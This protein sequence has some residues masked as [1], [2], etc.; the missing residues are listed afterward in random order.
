MNI[1]IAGAGKVGYAVARQLVAEG[2]DVALLDADRALLD[3]AM[4]AM[5]VIG[6]C[7]NSANLS[8]LEEAEVRK[9]DIFIAATSA[10]EIN[11]VSCQFAKKLGARYTMARIRNPEYMDRIDAMRE[12]MELSLALNPDQVG[13]EEIS[14]VLQ[15]PTA[16]RVEVFPDCD[17]EIVTARIPAESRLHGVTLSEL[18]RKFGSRVLVCAV[19]RGKDLVIPKGGFVLQAGD[20]MTVTGT[21]HNLRRFFTSAGDYKKPVRNVTILGGSRIAVYLTLLLENTGV[22]VTVIEKDPDRARYLSEILREAD[23]VCAD[24]T[25]TAALQETGLARA[26]GFVALTNFDEDNIIISMYADKL[27]VDKVICKVNNEKFTELL[28]GSFRDTAV[29]PKDLMAQ[30]IVG[31]VRAL[32]NTVGDSTM[33]ALYYLC[34]GRVVATEFVAGPAARCVGK[35]LKDM[36]LRE[37]VLLAC[38]IRG[39]KSYIP[40]GHT[41]IRPGDKVVVITTNRAI[42]SL[43]EILAEG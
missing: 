31:F 5:D 2:H 14:R 33:E 24:G 6:Y 10:D 39:G 30:R 3:T 34:E 19:E 28:G 16:T 4:N 18:E 35:A 23:I 32:D 15:F 42:R 13:A 20:M 26:D 12:I 9:A 7:G 1:I 27:G 22:D 37:G 11:L 38:V 40:D 25:D 41:E 8:V 43:D 36:R 21:A 17:F 29:S